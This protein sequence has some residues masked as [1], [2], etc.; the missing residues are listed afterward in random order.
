MT[1]SLDDCML[2]PFEVTRREAQQEIEAHDDADWFEF[3]E[4]CG[5]R[6]LYWSNEVLGWLGY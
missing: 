3:V 6:E 1:Y 4:E 5:D 2:T